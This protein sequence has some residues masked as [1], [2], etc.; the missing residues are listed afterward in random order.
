MGKNV[1]KRSLAWMLAFLMI[2]AAALQTPLTAYADDHGVDVEWGNLRNSETNNG[3]TDRPAITGPEFANLKW[4]AKYGTGWAAA[5]TP[6]LILDGYLYSGVGNQVVKIDMATGAEVARSDAMVGNVG[7]GMNP[8]VYGNGYL[9]VQ[10]ASGRIQ[11]I[12]FD[13]LTCAWAT[14][15]IGGQ[16]VSPITYHENSVT[17]KGYVYLG[18]WGGEKKDG[19]FFC[20]TA[21]EEDV[22]DGIK[23]FKWIFTPSADDTALADDAHKNRGFY[24]AGSYATDDYVAVGSDD[25]T[26]EGDY[27]ANAVFY[28]LDPETGTIIDR[29]GQIKGDIRSTAVYD[30][31]YLYFN[32]KGGL[33]YRTAVDS[34]GQFSDTSSMDLGGMTTASALI[35]NNRLYLGVCGKGGQFD[36]DAGHHFAVVDVSGELS[37]GSI[38]YDIPIKGY[39][40][41]AALMST[42]EV[43]ED[44][45]Q[46]GKADGRV[47]IYFTYNAQPGGVYY[48]YDEPGQ[49]EPSSQQGELFIPPTGLQ[50]YCISTLCMDRKGTIYYKNDSCNLFAIENN[51]AYL[52]D[53]TVVPDTGEAAWET[54]YRT[55]QTEYTL[56]VAPDATKVD[57]TLDLPEGIQATVNG[58]AYQG[59]AVVDLPAGQETTDATV[60]VTYTDFT[61]TYTFHL[62]RQSEDATLSELKVST[63][64][65]YPSGTGVALTTTFRPE[66]MEY[67]T[68]LTS[69]PSIGFLNVWPATT[70][71]KATYKVYP[72]SNVGAKTKLEADG[73]IA[74][75]STYA[76]HGR[77]AICP[78]NA[79][80]NTQIR[81]E[82]TSESGAK[83]S[84][85][86]L[87]L[88]TCVNVTDVALTQ[89]SLTLTEGETA[90]L[91]ATIAP[92][93]ATDQEVTWE[94]SD[95]NVAI[96]DPTGQV[97]AVAKGEATI[98]VTTADGGKQATCQVTVEGVTAV[99][100]AEATITIVAQQ[101]KNAYENVLTDVVVSAEAATKAGYSKAPE[102][103][104]QVTVIDALVVLHQQLYGEDF[105]NNPTKYLVMDANGFISTIFG[106]KTY[107]LGYFVNNAFPVYADN[108]KL[109]SVANDTV[110][111][112]TD[113]LN[114]F[115][116]NSPY[117]AEKYLYFGSKTYH[118]KT[119]T[120]VTVNVQGFYAMMERTPV[121]QEGATVVA[122]DANG[123]IVAEAITDADGNA[124]LT[125][126]QAGDYTLTVSAIEEDETWGDYFVA[127]YSQLTVEADAPAQPVTYTMLEGMNGEYILG[128]SV[129]A[130]FRADGAYDKFTGVSV[131]DILLGGDD[132]T[133]QSGSTIVN[134]LPGYLNTLSE[135]QHT[136]TIHYVDGAASTV[137]TLK[138]D[139]GTSTVPG[140]GT[141]AGTD[142]GAGTGAGQSTTKPVVT[143]LTVASTGA[144]AKTGDASQASLMWIL[145]A[146]AAGTLMMAMGD[147]KQRHHR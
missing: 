66:G 104:K 55:G 94:T 52:K 75:T 113:T 89:T 70:S 128:G 96:V 87:T 130:Y 40:Q 143:D 21:D 9:F 83:T 34:T 74:R 91:N 36:P 88:V 98:T 7:F 72:V 20:V 45:N 124:T 71:D 95:E 28:T 115:L 127:P 43:D 51:P 47:Y 1:G 125:L 135:G 86:T 64:N 112:N 79:K 142:P 68:Q 67:E 59:K 84:S 12:D 119:D 22:T 6:P 15:K 8:I 76:G 26:S 102:F 13:T 25:G 121:A 18:T 120:P 17:G 37:D 46:D 109:G 49:E 140:T 56:K 11:A 146:L 99:D 57:L 145:L 133:S 33:L 42:S 24:W 97:T 19:S 50:Q 65:S 147:R 116:Y 136:L 41:A 81:V 101:G 114:V 73:S 123:K 30:N 110:L 27:T 132:Y 118:T 31:G 93:N 131:D 137:F 54:A 44:Y 3:V 29:I 92:D 63:S 108:P 103:Q 100:P 38:I 39:P 62:V 105:S 69:L 138:A 48:I 61:R 122:Q 107:S 144:A 111:K 14:E 78:E 4:T 126:Q 77:Y 80:R 53:V 23:A 129:P 16:T 5:P 58:K 141:G 90:T 35:Y 60:Q 32:T 106:K 2:F 134:L 117:Y 82:V 10:V 139:A 85:Y